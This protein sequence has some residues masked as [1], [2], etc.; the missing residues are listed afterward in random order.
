[1]LEQSSGRHKLVLITSR[2]RRHI[3]AFESRDPELAG[4]LQGFIGRQG[5]HRIKPR[6][7]PISRCLTVGHTPVGVR[8]AR[9]AGAWSAAVL[10]GFGQRA[11]LIRAGAHL[12]LHSTGDL[13]TILIRC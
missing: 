13:A 8:T 3:A 9:L 5:T 6:S 1:M 7:A 4:H 12:V 2:G 11:K 10:G